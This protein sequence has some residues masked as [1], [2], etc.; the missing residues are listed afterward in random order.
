MNVEQWWSDNWQ[1]KT[2]V[3]G[4][5]PATVLLHHKSHINSSGI[6]PGSLQ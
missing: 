1:G 4:E 2:K 3:F 5:A 6:K